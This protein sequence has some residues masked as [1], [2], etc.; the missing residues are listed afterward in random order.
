[1]NR[2]KAKF[3]TLILLFTFSASYAQQ[4]PG[5]FLTSH[6]VKEIKKSLGKYPVFDRSYLE[7]KNIADAALRSEI[8][9]PIPKDGGGG[10]THEKHK[11][12]YYEMNAAGTLYQITGEKNTHNSYLICL[13]NNAEIYPTPLELTRLKTLTLPVNYFGRRLTKPFGFFIR[14]MLTI[15]STI[16][17]V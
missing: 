9:V 6:G 13:R 16:L 10:Y 15:A 3:I 11:N 17:S 14:P 2:V 8:T 7:L 12:N 1:M 5:L 4:H